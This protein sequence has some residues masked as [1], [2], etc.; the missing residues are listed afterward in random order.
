M[1]NRKLQRKHVFIILEIFHP[2]TPPSKK[3]IHFPQFNLLAFQKIYTPELR[4]GNILTLN[5]SF[6]FKRLQSCEY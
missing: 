4:I 3:K 6:L 1:K 2:N 5:I